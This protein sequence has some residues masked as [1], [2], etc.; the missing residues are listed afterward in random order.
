MLQL[1]AKGGPRMLLSL[2]SACWYLVFT[3]H[4]PSLSEVLRHMLEDPA[5]LE[6]WMESEIKNYFAQVGSH[7]NLRSPH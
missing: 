4:Q 3:R 7:C 6:S 1:L 5:T 2:P